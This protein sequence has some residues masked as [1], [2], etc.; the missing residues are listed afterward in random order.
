MTTS[1]ELLSAAEKHSVGLALPD[2][3]DDKVNG[4][5]A[6]ARGQLGKKYDRRD[7]VAALVFGGPLDKEGLRTLLSAYEDATVGSARLKGFSNAARPRR[8]GRVPA[9]PRA[10]G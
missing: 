9:R 5:L 3:L 6:I 4:L 2:V 8:P 1:S 7:I 10:P